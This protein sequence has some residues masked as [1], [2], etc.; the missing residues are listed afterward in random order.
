MCTDFGSRYKNGLK[1]VLFIL[2]YTFGYSHKN[3]LFTSLSTL[4]STVFPLHDLTH[5]ILAQDHCNELWTQSVVDFIS[6]TI[7]ILNTLGHLCKGKDI[8]SK[9][10]KK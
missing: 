10:K 8:R 6:I 1:D 2:S 9:L 4:T 7:W 3:I 5:L